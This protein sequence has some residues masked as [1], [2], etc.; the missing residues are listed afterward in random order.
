MRWRF[1]DPK[2]RQEIAE[3]NGVIERI[4]AW[5]RAFA[6]MSNDIPA[7]FAQKANWDLPEWM[8][9]HL[10]GI[11]P[12]LMWEFGGALK[13]PGHRLVITPE[14]EHHLRPLVR[15][16]L[17]RAPA[18]DGWEFYEYRL[19]EDLAM[20]FSAVQARTNRD[21]RDFKVRPSIGENQRIDLVYAAQ[22][23]AE[24]DDSSAL[25]AAFVATETLLGE[26]CLDN[27]IGA[28]DISTQPR[29]ED[30]D[31]LTTSNPIKTPRFLGLDRLH[32]TVFA[33]IDSIR[34]QLPSKPHFEW[35]DSA[36][37]TCWELQPE[38][39]EDFCQQKDLFI[40]KS[41]NPQQWSSARGDGL[42]S[43]ERFSRCGEIFCYVKIDG[44]EGL[45]DGEFQDKSE[46]EDAL[47][48]VLKPE[49]LG[50]YIGGGTGL[51]YSYVDL[52]LTNV[53][54][55]IEAVRRR[56][57]AGRVPHRSWIQF[58]D[59]DWAAEWVGVYDDTPPPPPPLPDW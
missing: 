31:S 9:E 49:G 29:P 37:W 16:I 1:I 8:E 11:D 55:G 20:T 50:C 52:A 17:E 15:A 7:V 3:R 43:S 28:I 48:E 59:S 44:S 5:W 24:L 54:R 12:N 14:S 13:G 40:G 58:F 2:N 26:Q 51:R 32:E 23:I 4:D 19:A 18:I 33:L 57:Q 34:E 56:L 30:L 38:E 41:V 10:E 6:S 47:N 42:F 39:A 22:S 45:G 46:I 35:V 25:N 36:R 53:E 27:W 21:I